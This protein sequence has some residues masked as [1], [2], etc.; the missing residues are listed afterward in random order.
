[1]NQNDLFLAFLKHA[2]G[3]ICSDIWLKNLLK[4]HSPVFRKGR[5]AIEFR[6]W[7]SL[8]YNRK[9]TYICSKCR[10]VAGFVSEPTRFSYRKVHNI[11]LL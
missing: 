9:I 8:F 6:K 1:M 4:T 11:K 10:F 3:Y 7:K 2:V 5:L